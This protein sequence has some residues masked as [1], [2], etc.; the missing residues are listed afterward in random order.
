MLTAI[1]SPL[2]HSQDWQYYGGDP[3]GTK[4][5][6]LKQINKSN[7]K[8]LKA[9]WIY[10]TGDFSDGTVYPIHSS[11][12]C[13]PLVVDGVMYVT[14]SFARVIALKAETGKLLWQFDPKLDRDR[15][16][17]QFINRG[18]AFWRR[19]AQKRIFV[20]TLD[21]RLFALN[22][23]DGTLVQTFGDHGFVNLRTGAAENY[24]DRFCGMTSPPLVYKN[25]VIT[26]LIVADSQPLGPSGD[27]RAYDVDTGKEVWRFHTVPRPGEAGHE[28]WENDSWKERGGTNP[29][30]I[31]SCDLERGILYLPLTSPSYDAY[32]G[33]RKGKNLF[34]DSLV[35]LDAASGKLIWYY[36]ILH[37]DIWDYDLPAQP[38]LVTLRR[39]GNTVPGVAQVTKQGFA[40]VFNRLT[41][42]PFFPIEERKVPASTVPGEEAWPTQPFPVKPPPFARQSI[43]PEDI[44]DVTPESRT[45]CEKML[46]GVHMGPLFQ[47]LGLDL[48]LSFPGGN[49]GANWGGASYD[50]VAN[51]LF[52]NSMDVAM[53]G[54]LAPTREG[55]KL[56]YAF[57]GTEYGWFWDS[58]HYPC[59]KPPWGTLTAINLNEGTISWQVPLGVV[60]ALIERGIPPTGAPNIGGSIVTAGGLV[61]IAATNDSRFRAF[62]KDT[63]QE[64]WVT[65]LP[66]SGFATPMTFRG[67]KTGKQFVVITAGGGNSYSK[68]FSDAVV[69]Y[70]LP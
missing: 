40:F 39:D 15:I 20:G 21:G 41:G 31:M 26:G 45:Y 29:W 1:V 65:K 19:G 18:A 64:L 16:Y 60:D 32:G 57:R 47:P 49:G 28:T 12:E 4:Y 14:T 34:G 61:F 66:A 24:P 38:D 33:D 2:G 23:D 42:E 5:S 30:S 35:A 11:F 51:L 7:V 3:G 56:R 46:E 43:S 55:S 27:V 69:A 62:D 13:T 48:T 70:S 36:Q 6:N 50:P 59:Q 10:H 17:P 53:V 68:V 67:S 44:T 52:V 63:G 58:N 22:A 54:R 8:I 25:L 9:A 37:H